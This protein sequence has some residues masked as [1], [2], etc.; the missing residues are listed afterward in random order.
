MEDVQASFINY[1][2]YWSPSSGFY[3]TGKDNRGIIGVHELTD[4]KTFKRQLK[5]FIVQ[6]AY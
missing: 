3:C 2:Y 1:L 4:T 6:Q 5:T